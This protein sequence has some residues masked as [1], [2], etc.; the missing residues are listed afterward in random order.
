MVVPGL[1]GTGL[2]YPKVPPGFQGVLIVCVFD[3]GRV[4]LGLQGRSFFDQM[5]VPGLQG[6]GLVYPK[7]PPG[8]QGVFVIVFDPKAPPR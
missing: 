5:V 2:V 1:Q 6:T 4:L 7:V 8:F 3:P